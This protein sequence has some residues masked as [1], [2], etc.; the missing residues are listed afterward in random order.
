M[1]GRV[2]NYGCSHAFGAE[3]AGRGIN[4]HYDN[5]RLNFG[6]LVAQHFN[7]EF[8][9]AARPGN[10]NRQILHDVMEFVQPGD[11]CLL[12]WTY[13]D[14]ERWILPENKDAESNTNY[15]SYHALR[16]LTENNYRGSLQ[17]FKERFFP[18][19]DEDDKKK[20]ESTHFFLKN[21]DNPIVQSV[22]RAHYDYFSQP[23]IQ[24]MNFLEIYQATNEI[25]K[26]RGAHA[27]NFH[28]DMEPEVQIN[29]KFFEEVDT[30]FLQ[31]NAGYYKY[32]KEYSPT[33]QEYFLTH[34][35]DTEQSSLYRY[36]Q[37][38][39]TRINWVVQEG[40]NLHPRSFKQWYTEKYH[41]DKD[42][43][44]DNRLGHLGGHGH[45]VLSEF[46]IPKVEEILYAN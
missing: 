41:G 17:T 19:K 24:T 11:I 12:S 9:I 20:I 1:S 25:I 38:D 32:D 33:V 16:V 27:V 28:F 10:S 15:T 36:Y 4:F 13:A 29:L 21:I 22:C 40:V 42:I 7:K 30:K 23:G 39:N 14:R 34:P 26:N 45:E 44:P 18:G 31:S 37:N 5:V 3:I 46:I 43:W 2:V 6:N 35:M 8:K